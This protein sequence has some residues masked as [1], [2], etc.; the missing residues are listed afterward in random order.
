[1]QKFN[2]KKKA[3]KQHYPIMSEKTT[4]FS[5]DFQ[6]FTNVVSLYTWNVLS[7]YYFHPSIFDV[8]IWEIFSL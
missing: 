2:L 3:V 7:K 4:N 1:M 6:Q 5:L 8:E